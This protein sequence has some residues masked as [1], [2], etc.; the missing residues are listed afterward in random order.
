MVGPLELVLDQDPSA[1]TNLLAQDVRAKRS[2]CLLLRLQLE[3]DSEY[4]AQ[5]G[6]I[7]FPCEPRGEITGLTAP[8]VA[9]LHRSKPAESPVVHVA[10]PFPCEASVIEREHRRDVTKP[11]PTGWSGDIR[12]AAG[13]AEHGV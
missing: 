2:Y 12:G 7:F 5:D 11:C 1:R 6:Q 9:E 3:V 10:V 13:G 8:D 4:L